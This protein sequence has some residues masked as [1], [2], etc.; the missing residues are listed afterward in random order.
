MLVKRCSRQCSLCTGALQR[1]RVVPHGG[2]GSFSLHFLQ[3]YFDFLSD[4]S[5]LGS[6]IHCPSQTFLQYVKNINN[7]NILNN[8]NNNINIQKL[9]FP[10]L[11]LCAGKTQTI[12][13]GSLISRRSCMPGPEFPP[14]FNSI[15]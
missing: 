5:I 11:S 8:I 10:P 15:S 1:R 3:I 7:V 2:K 12:G 9:L 6:D 14:F 4:T 13:R